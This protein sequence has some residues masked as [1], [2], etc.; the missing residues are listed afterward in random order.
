MSRVG[1]HP[2]D[3]PQGV[4][5]EVKDRAVSVKGKLGNLSMV[6]PAEI[7]AKVD[8]AKVAVSM[9]EAHMNNNSRVLWGTVR[10]NISNMVKGVSEGFKT[11]LEI[12]GVGFKAAM[13]GKDLVMQLGFSHEVRVTPPEGV[14]IKVDKPTQLTISGFDKQRVGQAAAEIRSF[15]KPEPYKGKGIKYAG[16]RI[17]RKEGK[18]K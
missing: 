8:G 17:R 15:R 9:N 13:Q 16:E 4:T 7:D 1:K 10:N 12:D 18:K 5:I 6:L 2:V 3:I 11:V 14:A